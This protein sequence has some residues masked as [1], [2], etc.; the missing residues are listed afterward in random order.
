MVPDARRVVVAHLGAGASLAAV[1]DGRSVDTTMGFT[2]LEGLVMATRSGSVDP[3]LLL[4]LEE[5]EGLTPHELADTLEHRSGLLGLTGTAD[6]REVLARE[7]SGA[8]LAVDV[9]SHRLAGSIAA[10]TV[11]LA[12]LDVL[13]FTG[14][15]G[16]HSPEIRRRACA[17]LHHLGVV[18]DTANNQRAGGDS[19]IGSDESPVKVLVVTCREDLEIA[20]GVDQALTKPKDRETR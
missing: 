6:M 11:A 16:E 3:G 12:G 1:L 19:H 7:D 2:P 9:Y 18:I 17:P 15:V 8:Q 5:H 10:M 20:R 13:V 14:G 4:W